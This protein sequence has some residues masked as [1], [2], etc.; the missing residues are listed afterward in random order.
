MPLVKIELKKGP[1]KKFLKD[2]MDTVHESM[3]DVLSIPANDRNQRMYE[4]D[5]NLFEA[6]PPYEYF[7]EITMFKG[8]SKEIKGK[9][10]KTIVQ[11][12]EK[13]LSID[14]QKVFIVI[15]EQPLENWG[16]RGGISASDISF[17]F[18]INV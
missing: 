7:I 8:R 1:S 11:N 18:D 14:P 13:E 4:F 2:F 16:V 3:I 6:K 17:G 15:N 5:P 9:L 12:L 10:F